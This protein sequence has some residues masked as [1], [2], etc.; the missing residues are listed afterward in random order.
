MNQQTTTKMSKSTIPNFENVDRFEDI[1][2]R[3]IDSAQSIMCSNE[4]VYGEHRWQIT[5]L[6]LYLF[7]N[8]E[9]WRDPYIHK[10]DEQRESGTWYVHQRGILK[11]NFRAPNWS[12]IDITCGSRT[13]DIYGGLLIRQISKKKGSA[14]AMKAIVRG[15]FEPRINKDKWTPSESKTIKNEI[16]KRKIDSDPPSLRLE[17]CTTKDESLWIGPRIGLRK[18]DTDHKNPEGV[19]FGNAPLRIATWQT[20][21]NKSAMKKLEATQ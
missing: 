16:H 11:P 4:L 18:R 8:S 19:S 2:G 17:P 21:D 3:F 12:G 14:T 10:N 1:K 20:T 15:E 9:I 6:E 13:K 5:A 7:T